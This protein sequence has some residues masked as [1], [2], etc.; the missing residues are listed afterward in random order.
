LLYRAMKVCLFGAMNEWSF[1]A[2]YF[3][4][5]GAPLACV[6]AAPSRFHPVSYS[7]F[8]LF[9]LTAPIRWLALVLRALPKKF[10]ALLVES[11]GFYDLPAAKVVAAIKRVPLLWF[12]L[13]SHYNRAVED[14]GYVKANSFKARLLAWFDRTECRLADKVLLNTNQEITYYVQ[15]FGLPREKFVRVFLGAEDGGP[16]P[17]KAHEGFNAVFWGR[18]APIHGLDVILQAAKLL[19]TDKTIRLTVIGHGD[20]GAEEKLRQR[21]HDLALKNVSLR[22]FVPRERLREAVAEADVVLGIFADTGKANFVVPHKVYEA[23]SFAKPLVTADTPAMRGAG[24]R[25]NGHALLVQPE[26]PK[27]LADAIGRLKADS[28]L[29]ER[30]AE[31]G[32]KRFGECFSKQAAGKE[33]LRGLQAIV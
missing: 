6:T 13:T 22:G 25:N 20:K 10:D 15:K 18:F 24:I 32:R 11:P 33:L 14:L 7:G 3:K 8:A 29:R 31:N 1:C 23:L 28:V 5:N 26:N 21:V 17:A 30:L 2:P 9:L 19:E 16:L 4:E 12:P 27:A